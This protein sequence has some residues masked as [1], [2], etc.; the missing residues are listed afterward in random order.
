MRKIVAN[1][2]WYHV[3]CINHHLNISF[4]E[5]W[6]STRNK[7]II[8][9]TK[10]I[11]SVSP[12]Q[13]KLQCYICKV[14][15]DGLQAA[16]LT[17]EGLGCKKYF[18]VRC[19]IERGIVYQWEILDQIRHKNLQ[20]LYHLYCED[21]LHLQANFNPPSESNSE[22][23]SSQDLGKFLQSVPPKK[24]ALSEFNRAENSQSTSAIS[25][26]IKRPQTITLSS[27]VL[28]TGAKRK[29]K[30]TA[31]LSQN[32]VKSEKSSQGNKMITDY[33]KPFQSKQA[34]YQ[35]GLDLHIK[36]EESS[37]V[38]KP[39][40]NAARKQTS[41]HIPFATVSEVIKEEAEEELIPVKQI[42]KPQ[43]FYT[44]SEDLGRLI[45]LS[46]KKKQPWCKI[47]SQFY[48]YVREFGFLQEGQ[49]LVILG[50]RTDIAK[51]IG[52]SMFHIGTLH[53]ELVKQFHIVAIPC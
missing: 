42:S 46:S 34:Q 8:D 15:S 39:K 27:Q 37:P 5:P 23:L 21:H 7:H 48:N 12:V 17:C 51:I 35:A 26:L 1:N 38:M 29:S 30:L 20:N 45:G 44:I 24:I 31:K 53:Q 10:I 9:T 50:A 3:T 18:H 33:Y 13:F 4:N 36:K 32:S 49:T 19:G 11:G 2:E 28:L 43:E 41:Q 25:Q 22:S 52:S 16:C 6:C 47:Q 40:Q 14:K